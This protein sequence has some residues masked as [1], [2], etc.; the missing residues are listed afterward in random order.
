MILTG[1]WAY[2]KYKKHRAKQEEL[3]ASA[4]TKH[5]EL[6]VATQDEIFKTAVEDLGD[7]KSPAQ[8]PERPPSYS[9]IEQ[10][11]L[12]SPQWRR[13]HP[14]SSAKS[15]TSLSDGPPREV[16]EPRGTPQLSFPGS[17]QPLLT[18][19]SPSNHSLALSPSSS[20]S[21]AGQPAE[22]PVHG[23]WVWVPEECPRPHTPGSQSIPS[24]ALGDGAV[25][26]LHVGASL[27]ELPSTPRSPRASEEGQGRGF[28]L[29]ELDSTQ[30][31]RG[32]PQRGDRG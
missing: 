23:K 24:T 16:Y 6:I 28:G 18:Q 2:K 10:E 27:A 14:S 3:D 22:I 29:A 7:A 32:D 11:P 5:G 21:A 13:L 15:T 8:Q 1:R 30:L 26:E 25:A 20:E 4:H 31:L 17:P 19:T 12:T 9:R